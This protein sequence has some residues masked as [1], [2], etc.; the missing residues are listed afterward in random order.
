MLDVALHAAVEAGEDDLDGICLH[1]CLCEQG[2]ERRARPL[3]RA[4]RFKKPRLVLDVRLEQRA[5]VSRAFEGHCERSRRPRLQVVERQRQR[6]LDE[7]V[8]GE[9]PRA[10]VD[11]RGMSKWM[12]R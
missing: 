6:L 2:C 5:S 1:A 3:S 12:S 7:P 10:H 8:D 4:D 11:V 9:P